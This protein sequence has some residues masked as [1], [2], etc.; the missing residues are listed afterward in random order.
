MRQLSRIRGSRGL[1]LI[2]SAIVAMLGA[3]TSSAAASTPTWTEQTPPQHPSA[4]FGAAMAQD[5]AGN[6]LLFGGA[7]LVGGTLTYLGDTWSWNGSGWKQRTPTT[8]PSPRVGAMVAFDAATGTDVLFGGEYCNPS[9]SCTFYDDT[10][11][12]NGRTW[13]QVSPTHHP[14]G[15]DFAGGAY[16]AATG[17]V[18]L[19]GGDI[20]ASAAFDTWTWDGTDWTQQ[21]PAHIPRTSG[22]VALAYDST[23]QEAILF[24]G[25]WSGLVDNVTAVWNGTDWTTLSLSATPHAREEAAMAD[26]PVTGQLIL[27]G[28]DTGPHNTFS[29]TWA[30]TASHEWVQLTPATSPARRAAASM[31]YDSASSQIVLFGGE[32]P[33]NASLMV[34]SD[35]WA[36]E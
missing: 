21:L 23:T 7:G 20:G 22:A 30:F 14:S 24:G 26:D 33:K 28:G 1:L 16:D 35:T 36:Y 10:W 13:R 3:L 9:N 2:L 6:E 18:L 32:H 8:S 34:F 31:S 4:R 15:R 19:Y 5:P 27:F 12:W 29:D 25:Q 17:T 11:L